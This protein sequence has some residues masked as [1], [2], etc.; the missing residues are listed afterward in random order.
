MSKYLV[1]LLASCS[2]Q[3]YACY[4]V[5]GYVQC[6]PTP[7]IVYVPPPVIIIQQSQPFTPQP[8]LNTGTLVK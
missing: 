1:L 8:P 4:V 5:N 6:P 2:S 3:A 7:Q